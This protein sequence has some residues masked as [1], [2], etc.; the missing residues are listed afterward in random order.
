MTYK[1]SHG[2]CA[3]AWKQDTICAGEVLTPSAYPICRQTTL[4]RSWQSWMFVNST[5][6]HHGSHCDWWRQY[7]NTDCSHA[8]FQSRPA[9]EL[10]L[11]TELLLA[12]ADEASVEEDG[13]EEVAVLDTALLESTPDKD[14]TPLDAEL[15]DAVA[16]C[17]DADEP[18]WED[19]PR[20]DD[21]DCSMPE[22]RELEDGKPELDDGVPSDAG[23]GAPSTHSPFSQ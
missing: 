3:I 19:E 11:P 6:C 16:E 20:R 14:V 8:W 7:R 21:D 18:A 17:D 13:T 15:D 4:E 5:A 23:V 12:P 22:D 1:S 2:S 9:E 10:L